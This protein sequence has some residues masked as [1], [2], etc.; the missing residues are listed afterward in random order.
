LPLRVTDGS[1]KKQ[2]GNKRKGGDMF[3]FT[4]ITMVIALLFAMGK[5]VWGKSVW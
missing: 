3:Y 1:E 2:E 5:S 4:N